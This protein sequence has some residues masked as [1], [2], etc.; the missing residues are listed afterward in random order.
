MIIST[1]KLFIMNR[2]IIKSIMAA[3]AALIITGC[4]KSTTTH[5]IPVGM[6]AKV[7]GAGWAA[8]SYS[9]TI[10]SFSP[11][12]HSLLIIGYFGSDTTGTNVSLG[13]DNYLG[14]TGT[15]DIALVGANEAEYDDHLTGAYHLATSGTITIT[16][17]TPDNIQGTYNFVS[18]V[19]ISN[20]QFNV[21]RK[22]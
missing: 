4:K 16:N 9:F 6:S 22:H 14:A 10:D 7:N 3:A 17:Y 1:T 21:P 13:V 5:A 12:Q 8:D 18:D 2:I 11:G 20:G 15:F 19:S